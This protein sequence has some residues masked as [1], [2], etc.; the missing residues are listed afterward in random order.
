MMI[1][2]I[3]EF[4]GERWGE[5]EEVENYRCN[6]TPIYMD[7]GLRFNYI[8]KPLSYEMYEAVFERL[9][10]EISEE[11]SEIYKQCNG[12]RLLLSG[13]SIYGLQGGGYEMEPYDLSLENFR[14]LQEMFGNGCNTQ[15]YIF[16]GAYGCDYVFAYE[17]GKMD[18]VYCMKQGYDEILL[19]FN[20]VRETIEYFI[21]RIADCYDENCNKKKQNGE[22]EGIPFLANSMYELDELA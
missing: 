8:F 5:W 9:G 12:M 13:F 16:W 7:N 21:P 11:L 22:F 1:N 3:E 4:L 2:Y 10:A 15:K 6:G 17:K 20:S 18:K 19:T 14:I